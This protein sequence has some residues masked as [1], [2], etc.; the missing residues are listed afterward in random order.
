VM[1]SHRTTK[2]ARKDRGW[3]NGCSDETSMGGGL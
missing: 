1:T 3:T 2:N